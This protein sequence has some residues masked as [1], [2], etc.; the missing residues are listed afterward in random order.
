MYARR[1]P[2]TPIRMA[3]MT[4]T[5]PTPDH[6]DTDTA[7]KRPAYQPRTVSKPHGLSD[8]TRHTLSLLLL[9][10]TVFLLLPGDL[11]AQFATPPTSGEYRALVLFVRFHD[12]TTAYRD[13]R[14]PAEQAWAAPDVLPP[15]AHDLLAPTP[16]PPFPESSLTD[17][18]YRQSQGRFTLYGTV[19][20]HVLVTDLDEDAY[21]KNASS[22]LLSM[23]M[24]T[25]ELLDRIDADPDVDLS[26]YDANGDGY[27]DQV[28]FVL[29]RLCHLNL[30]GGASG[31]SFLGYHSPEPEFGDDPA[32]LK[33]VDVAYSGSYLRYGS[34]GIIPQVNLV[35][36]MAHEFGHDLWKTFSMGHINSMNEGGGV[37]ANDPDHIGYALMT[38]GGGGYDVRGDE[39]ISAYERDLLRE[40][41]ITCRHLEAD[42]TVAVTDLYSDPTANCYTLT[43]PDARLRPQ[44]L[45]LSNRQ[46]VGFFDRQRTNTCTPTP[47][48]HGLKTTGL[49]ATLTR[50]NTMAVLAADNTLHRSYEAMPYAGDLFSPETAVQLTPWTLPNINGYT[51]YPAAF[52]PQD[53]NFQA[54]LNIRYTGHA[55]GEMAFDYV[56]DF[57]R[58]PVIE[59]DS[60]IGDETAGYDFDDLFV[61]TNASVLT[62]DTR[63]TFSDTLRLETGSTVVIGSGGRLELPAG[64]LLEMGDGTRLIVHGRLISNGEVRRGRDAT[65]DY[66][67]GTGVEDA[68]DREPAAG[69]SLTAYPNPFNTTATLRY[70]L[71][72]A[73]YV[74]LAVYDALGRRV[75]LLVA[76]HQPAGTH[77]ARWTADGLPSGAYH[78]RLETPGGITTTTGLLVK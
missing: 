27:L 38:G 30:T 1:A 49:L 36:L 31:C 66:D 43:L 52:T 63:L 56:R 77:T 60:W 41:W 69:P 61:V 26:A 20:P 71:A 35:R 13:T 33:R 11:G 53:D 76:A 5:I 47:N 12:D 51:V 23:R 37:P 9:L 48:A 44:T 22:D 68:E 40:P 21:R 2:Q 6:P 75:A 32:N 72:A 39:L 3:E 64:S 28:F 78:Y 17:Y 73:G 24:L 14:T 58:R 34:A 55:D 59:E 65:I 70:T 57:R 16:Y 46:R 50:Q 45:Y 8:T 74:R 18:F 62:I 10:L 7:T 19:Y 15:F 29:R 54:I 67:V 42:T 25:K 4:L